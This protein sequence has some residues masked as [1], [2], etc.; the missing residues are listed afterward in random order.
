MRR[1]R[2]GKSSGEDGAEFKLTVFDSHA[3]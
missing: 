3:G 2:E 1:E